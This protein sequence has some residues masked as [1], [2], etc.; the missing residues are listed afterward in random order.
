MNSH[1][2]S[3]PTTWTRNQSC[4]WNR[5]LCNTIQVFSFF[6]FRLSL[7]ASDYYPSFDATIVRVQRPD[8]TI[9]SF[10]PYCN[11]NESPRKGGGGRNID[12]EEYWKAKKIKEK[13][14]DEAFLY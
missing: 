9:V 6:F 7:E 10:K 1:E 12:A 5:P 13:E 14:S 8:G 11:T 4:P 3:F 2:P